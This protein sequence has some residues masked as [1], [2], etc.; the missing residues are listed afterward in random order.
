[1]VK[2]GP[3]PDFEKPYAFAFSASILF[4]IAIN[5]LSSLDSEPAS[6]Q[7]EE[8]DSPYVTVVF[9]A[10]SYEA[11]LNDIL[12]GAVST[13][14]LGPGVPGPIQIL[15]AYAEDLFERQVSTQTKADIVHLTLTGQKCPWDQLPYQDWKLLAR[16]RNMIMH[17]RA[18]EGYVDYSDGIGSPVYPALIE[19]L[20]QRGLL[21]TTNWA[22]WHPL[23]KTHALA[24]WAVDVAAKMATSLANRIPPNI[25]QYF[26][27]SAKPFQYWVAGDE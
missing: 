22:S 13:M 25:W 16:L 27:Y 14:S 19:V 10:A 11:L 17:M 8:S 3:F 9:A 15:S 18:G 1:M 24:K 2:R 7:E 5:A 20:K 23:I 26:P 6:I 12:Y 21:S 4:K